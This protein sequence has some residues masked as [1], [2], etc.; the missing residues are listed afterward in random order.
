MQSPARSLS[1][2]SWVQRKKSQLVVL[3]AIAIYRS[4]CVDVSLDHGR[5][6][7]CSYIC[8]LE[9]SPMGFELHYLQGLTLLGLRAAESLSQQPL[10]FARA[11]RL[12]LFNA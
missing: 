2:A 5:G 3:S 6:M 9:A 4:R 10:Y 1:P 11:F 8:I 7:G 12:N